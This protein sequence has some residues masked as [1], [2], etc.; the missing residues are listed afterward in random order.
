MF[1]ISS[2]CVRNVTKKKIFFPL[3]K[4]I[5]KSMKNYLKIQTGFFINQK[6]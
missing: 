6:K 4:N 2:N 1:N 3:V 5:K